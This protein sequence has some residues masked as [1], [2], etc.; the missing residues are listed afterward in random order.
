LRQTLPFCPGCSGTWDSP[1]WFSLWNSWDYRYVP[2]HPISLFL[3]LA[4]SVLGFE[5]WASHLLDRCF[6][7]WATP[8]AL[9]RFGYF[10]NRVSWAICLGWLQIAIIL[11]SV[12]QEARSIDMNHQSFFLVVISFLPLTSLH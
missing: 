4:F 6:I 2:L 9:F 7:T 12:S 3:C 5:F 8:P 11:I 10:W 1:A